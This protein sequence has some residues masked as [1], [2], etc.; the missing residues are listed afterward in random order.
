MKPFHYLNDQWVTADKLTISVFDL[1]VIRGFGVFDFLRTYNN[2]PFKLDEHV[3][4]LFRSAKELG[5]TVPKTKEEIKT[6]ILDGLQKNVFPEKNVR[7]VVTGGISDDGVSLGKPSLFV[8]FTE[9]HKYPSHY[10]EKGIKVI[11][12][13]HIRV[14]PGAKSLNYQTGIIALQKAKKENAVEAIFVG[15]DG[16]IFEGTTSNF[17][18]VIDG[19]LIT[20]E[21]DVLIGITRNVVIDIAKRLNVPVVER[22]I[23]VKEI[24]EMEEAFITASN[25]EV[26]PVVQIDG[27]RVKNGKVGKLTDILIREYKRTMIEVRVSN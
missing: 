13:P 12:F 23:F 7:I 2:K 3:D 20:P 9:A 27:I 11:T 21:K 6:I 22:D 24:P 19:K 14:Y 26:M 15:A 17:F 1:S 10:Y 5:I 8:I 25:K 18:A 16:K 4:R